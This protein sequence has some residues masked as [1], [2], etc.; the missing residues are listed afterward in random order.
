MVVILTGWCGGVVR[1]CARDFVSKAILIE[2]ELNNS[3]MM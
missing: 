3:L 1:V 2:I